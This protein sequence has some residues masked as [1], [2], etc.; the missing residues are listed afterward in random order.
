MHL[1]DYYISVHL[2]SLPTYFHLSFADADA[3]SAI[4]NRKDNGSMKKL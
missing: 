1:Y 2:F 4:R 3:C